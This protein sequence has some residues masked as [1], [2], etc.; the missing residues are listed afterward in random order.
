M[1]CRPGCAACCIAP[2]ISSPIPGMPDGKP[3]GVPCVQLD[4]QLGCKLFGQADRPAVCLS[5][6]PHPEMC[7][8]HRDDALHYLTWL[9]RETGSGRPTLT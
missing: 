9:E 8:Q 2:S 4:A 6:M 3:A 1:D 7:G 5:L